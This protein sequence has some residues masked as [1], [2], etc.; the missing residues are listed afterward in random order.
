[1]QEVEMATYEDQFKE[2]FT[3][4]GYDSIFFPKTR[5]KTMTEKERRKVDGCA[6]FYRASR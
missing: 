2:H 6:T 1:M 5:A 4:A 3:R